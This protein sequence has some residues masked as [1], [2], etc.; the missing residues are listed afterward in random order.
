MDSSRTAGSRWWYAIAIL[1]IGT[2]LVF[3]CRDDVQTPPA[4]HAS[5]REKL[6]AAMPMLQSPQF[7]A[8]PDRLLYGVFDGDFPK[9]FTSLAELE[10]R[11]RALFPIISVESDAPQFPLR[12]ADTIERLGSVPLITWTSK[13]ASDAEITAWAAEAAKFGQPIYLRFDPAIDVAAWKHVRLLFRKM[14]A[15][16]VIWVWSFG[17]DYPGPEWVD[18]VGVSV[19]NRGSSTFQ[20][21]LGPAYPTLQSFHK[22]VMITEFGTRTSA[23]DA[24]QWYR[25]AFRDLHEKDG[26]V[27][28]VI[29][30]HQTQPIVWSLLQSAGATVVVRNE[31]SRR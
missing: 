8:N 25:T 31:L 11:T 10:Q 2:L 7:L 18:W 20:Q 16:N 27:R 21:I 5:R 17:R 3:S 4:R 14:N 13:A 22:P 24:A 23:G 12:F 29:F 9:S 19:L 15:T 26:A 30:Y 1:A 28:A 6:A